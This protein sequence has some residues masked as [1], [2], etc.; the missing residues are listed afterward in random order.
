MK[1]KFSIV[2]PVYNSENSLKQLYNRTLIELI[3]L[4]K[5]YEFIFIDD[6]SS[7]NSFKIIE[8]LCQIDKN[9]IGIKLSR[10]YGQQNAVFC[11]LEHSTG[12]YIINMDDDLQHDP[13]YIK[14]MY[15]ELKKGY[16]IVYAVTKVKYHK[17]Y[18]NLGSKLTDKMFNILLKKPKDKRVSSYRIMNKN[19]K[20]IIVKEK[21]T[22]NYISASI[23][24]H[25]KKIGNIHYQHSTRKYGD[26][27][28][29]FLKQLKI[30]IR[31][32]LY[33]SDISIFRPFLSKSESYSIKTIINNG[34]ES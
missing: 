1:D 6:N 31:I 22:Y 20:Q 7:D 34:K 2:I 5:L 16:D 4:D 21:K 14:Y 26:S 9:I 28:Y 29:T 17:S 3:K 15:N 19:L 30:F 32:F 23:L 10:N 8:K 13:K 11:G 12:D 18:R 24:K 25:S 27:N 33:Y